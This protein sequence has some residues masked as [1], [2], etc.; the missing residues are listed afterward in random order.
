MIGGIILS[1]RKDRTNNKG[2]NLSGD[3]VNLSDVFDH[4]RIANF[5]DDV[6]GVL[7]WRGT[8]LLC[9]I[10]IICFSI[11]EVLFN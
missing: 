7:G 10:L 8:G 5:S 6:I 4:S 11:F 9:I 2:I 1:F 3:N